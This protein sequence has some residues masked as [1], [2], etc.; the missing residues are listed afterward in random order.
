MKIN[1][2]A[3]D[4]LVCPFCQ[5]VLESIGYVNCPKCGQPL[6]I[7]VYVQSAGTAIVPNRPMDYIQNPQTDTD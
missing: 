3:S 4:V 1:G 2:P 6:I 7:S 5:Q